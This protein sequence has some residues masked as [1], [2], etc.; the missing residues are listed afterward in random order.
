MEFLGDHQQPQGA[1]IDLRN[2]ITSRTG[3]QIKFVSTSFGGLI[4]ALLTGQYDIILAQLFIKPPRLQEK[5]AKS[6]KK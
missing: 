6:S 4:P 5:P 3:M 1:D 2:V